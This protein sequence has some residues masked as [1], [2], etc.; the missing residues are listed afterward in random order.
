MSRVTIQE[1]AE[2]AGVSPM[3]V[4]RA[5]RNHPNVLPATR[6]R[7]LAAAAELG[8]RPH[9][10][11]AS[12]MA[13]IR[14]GPRGKTPSET[15]AFVTVDAR[16]EG[17]R[18]GTALAYYKGASERA[19]ELGFNLEEFWIMEPGL[20]PGRASQI[21]HTRN[22]RGLLIAPA[23]FP[24]DAVSLDWEN[25]AAVAFG[26]S[27][28]RPRLHRVTNHQIHS[29]RLAVRTLR[30]RGY[31]RIGLA[32]EQAADDRVDNNWLSGFLYSYYSVSSRERVKPY[33][34]EQMDEKGFKAWYR[35]HRPEA[36]L[37]G[38]LKIS[39]WLGELGESIPGDVAFVNLDYY[40]EAGKMAG[41]DQNSRAIGAAAVEL[42]AE[43]LYHNVRGIPE[44]PKVLLVDSDWVE[45]PT[46][47]GGRP[48]KRTPPG[49]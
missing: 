19:A 14:A 20:T 17:W 1:V 45:G 21:L 25:F 27:I 4:S 16:R 49:P 35:R 9:P 6:R 7:I 24:M 5:L 41:I 34:P 15:I 29:V 31:R 44:K 10:L 43:Q 2:R 38:D 37:A 23:P 46:V 11:V 30:E 36:V 42:L 32:L 48:R 22:T 13:S 33:V 39:R 12:L 18:H 47:R 28:R 3:T 8:Y 40:P 26:Y